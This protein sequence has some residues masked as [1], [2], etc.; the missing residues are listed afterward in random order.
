MPHWSSVDQRQLTSAMNALLSPLSYKTRDDWFGAISG[1]IRPLFRG[2]STLIAYV[3]GRVSGHFSADAPDLARRVESFSMSRHGEIHFS[4]E[5]METGMI[6]RRR[7]AMSVFTSA[8]LDQLSGGQLR[9]SSVYNEVSVHFGARITYAVA[10]TGTDGEALLGVNAARP[11][12]DPLSRDTLALLSLLAA[13][14]QAGF[15]ILGRLEAAHSALAATVDMLSDGISIYDGVQ[16]TE[17]H[18]N[19]ALVAFLAADAESSIVED[20]VRR[21][22]RSLC[23][24]GRSTDAAS[25]VQAAFNPELALD[26]VQTR[27]ARYRLRA[28]FVPPSVFAREQVVLV[29]VERRGILLPSAKALQDRFGLTPREAEVALRLAQ[30]DSDAALARTLG[31]S[32]HTVRHHTERVFDKLHV[33]SRKALALWLASRQIG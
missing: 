1:E 6:S 13:P 25:R 28:S 33:R 14:F 16:A 4:D 7:R 30:G 20:R 32:P 11:R 21:L 9:K 2:E 27:V 24:L 3:S 17:I 15:E 23:A 19:P 29:A 10:I 5:V 22:A 8:L 12:R 18:R 31:V 26:D